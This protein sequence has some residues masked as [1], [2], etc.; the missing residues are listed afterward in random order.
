VKD[1]P[2][3]DSATALDRNEEMDLYKHYK[4]DG[5]WADKVRLENPELH[6][7]SPASEGG[8]RN[9]GDAHIQDKRAGL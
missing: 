9:T 4:R 2:P 3:Y 5:Y 6:T 1:A 8:I 7:I